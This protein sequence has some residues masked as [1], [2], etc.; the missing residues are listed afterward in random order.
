MIPHF[1]NKVWCIS[2]I[3]LLPSTFGYN[4][5]DRLNRDKCPTW[6]YFQ[7]QAVSPRII[8][9]DIAPRSVPWQAALYYD[10]KFKC[11][12]VLIDQTT[13]LTAAHCLKSGDF[14]LDLDP[15]A[16]LVAVGINDKTVGPMVGITPERIIKHPK[17]SVRKTPSEADIAIIKLPWKQR[18]SYGFNLKSSHVK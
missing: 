8:D 14:Y 13:I 9:G 12:A 1:E 4:Y 5:D 10:G 15:K 18:I 17:Y 6:Q 7:F 2:I 3:C 16:Y 11:G